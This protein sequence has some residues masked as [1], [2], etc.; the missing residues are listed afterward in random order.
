MG[1][2]EAK[3]REVAKR[4]GCEYEIVDEGYFVKKGEKIVKCF[5]GM[6]ELN[7]ER[8]WMQGWGLLNK[9]EWDEEKD[10]IIK[11]L[12]RYVSENPEAYK[13]VY[14]TA[15]KYGRSRLYVIQ[16]TS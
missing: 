4:I 7:S 11:I 12:Q 14:R 8:V 2:V 16:K 6:E 1:N 5:K 15:T 9:E 3:V 13:L 10:K